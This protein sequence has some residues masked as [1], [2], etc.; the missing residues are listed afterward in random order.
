MCEHIQSVSKRSNACPHGCPCL[1]AC[2]ICHSHLQEKQSEISEL[3]TRLAAAA[4]RSVALTQAN[5]QLDAKLH[6]AQAAA[7]RSALTQSRL[8][9]EKEILEK[10]NAWLSQVR[11]ISCC[12]GLAC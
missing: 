1:P 3:Q 12:S 7:S 10:T 6:E 2:L 5:A 4:D 9:Q 8:E 11:L